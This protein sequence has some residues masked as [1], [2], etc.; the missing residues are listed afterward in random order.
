M[1]RSCATPTSPCAIGGRTSAESYLVAEKVLDAAR[2]SGADA[3]HPGYGFLSENPDFA[4][5]VADAGLAWIG[6]SPESMNAMALKVEAK[7]LVAAAGVPLVPGAELEADASD[8]DITAAGAAVGLP[9][10]VKAS[11]GGGG[12]GMRLV[13]EPD[14]L[15][16]AVSAARN[17]AASAFGDPTR[18]PRALP[19]ARSARR[20]A[21]LRRHPRQR[22]ARLRARVLDPAPPS[23]GRGGVPLARGDARH[24]GADVRRRRGR[25]AGR[26]TT[27]GPGPWSS[28]SPVR[29]RT[30]SSSSSR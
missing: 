29:V 23:E 3:I 9:L 22:G 17:E 26:S 16:E 25:C 12:K 4:R 11:A 8:A 21:G 18:L 10:L 15:L 13:R 20:G 7:R 1:P 24:A 6:P 14:E 2:R 28:W 5:A 30:R 27:S 19:G